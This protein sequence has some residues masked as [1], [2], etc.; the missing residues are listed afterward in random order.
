MLAPTTRANASAGL[1]APPA[2]SDMMKRMMARL[3][4]VIH[5]SIAATTTAIVGSVPSAEMTIFRTLL[6][7][8]APETPPS[9]ESASSIKPRPIQ[10]RPA[11]LMRSLVAVLNR[12]TPTNS[13]AA[14]SH[15]MSKAKTC[16]TSVV[17][18]SAPSMMAS[19]MG[20][21]TRPR[22]AKDDSS[23]AV[24]VELC[25]MPVTPM[26]VAKAV[27]RSRD[28]RASM[29]RSVAP[30][31]RVRPVRTMRTP[32]SRSATAPSNVKSR[33]LPPNALLSPP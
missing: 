15:L 7:R 18:T 27:M 1:T 3:E 8:M 32:H 4:C 28:A 10:M 12:I 14:Q 23:R 19:A 17:P 29:A 6:S 11:L 33:S 25:T 5:V 13:P 31:V 21:V 22:P 24:A 9:T 2:D 26:P 16:A 30:K 20:S